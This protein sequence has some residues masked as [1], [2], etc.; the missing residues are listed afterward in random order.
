MDL[1]IQWYQFP[2]LQCVKRNECNSLFLTALI[3]REV[4][5]AF[6]RMLKIQVP[7]LPGSSEGVQRKKTCPPDC[8]HQIMFPSQIIN[9]IKVWLCCS[10]L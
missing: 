2:P 10:P 4:K 3:K 9:E 5:A 6:S 8:Q 1:R 7:S